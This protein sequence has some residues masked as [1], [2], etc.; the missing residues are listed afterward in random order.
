M[1]FIVSDNVCMCILTCHHSI[2]SI[3]ESHKVHGLEFQQTVG[4]RAVLT[5]LL[6]KASIPGNSQATSWMKTVQTGELKQ[7][8]SWPQTTP[9]EKMN[10]QGEGWRR[11]V[12]RYSIIRLKIRMEGV[13]SF[14]RAS[15]KFHLW[16]SRRLGLN[17]SSRLW[18]LSVKAF[19]N[20]NWWSINLLAFLFP[21][22]S[23]SG[24]PRESWNIIFHWKNHSELILAAPPQP[25]ILLMNIALCRFLKSLHQQLIDLLKSK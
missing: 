18:L 7:W 11:L 17:W 25:I 8:P 14:L 1:R 19:P 22:F 20:P 16:W 13:L 12:R 2:F 6:P 3:L 21:L 15:Y 4:G 9:R 23:L 10:E 5:S 24:S